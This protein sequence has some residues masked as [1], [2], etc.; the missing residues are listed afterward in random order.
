MDSPEQKLAGGF[1]DHSGNKWLR[2]HVVTAMISIYNTI[3]NT[4]Q[5]WISSLNVIYNL[6]SVD[7]AKASCEFLSI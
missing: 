3:I 5:T 6:N 2:V 7:L 1:F 4:G